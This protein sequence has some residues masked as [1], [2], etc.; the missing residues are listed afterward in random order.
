MLAR[1]ILMAVLISGCATADGQRRGNDEWY[2]DA[3]AAF[4]EMS[5]KCTQNGGRIHIPHKQATRVVRGYTISDLQH[6]KCI[7]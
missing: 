4:I 1:Y 2:Y 7:W 5:E 3:A 6:A